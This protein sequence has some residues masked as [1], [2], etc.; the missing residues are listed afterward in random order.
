MLA[1]ILLPP[2]HHFSSLQL[3]NFGQGKKLCSRCT[4]AHACKSRSRQRVARMCLCL[5]KIKY[6]ARLQVV[7]LCSIH[8][9]HEA[10]IRLKLN[11]LQAK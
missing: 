4:A 2:L 8:I 6:R 10:D 9:T 11:P 7:S 3:V 1:L 5:W